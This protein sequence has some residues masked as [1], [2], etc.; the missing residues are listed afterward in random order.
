MLE[1][2]VFSKGDHNNISHSTC[3]SMIWCLHASPRDAQAMPSLESG[4]TCDLLVIKK[5]KMDWKWCCVTSKG[6]SHKAMQ[7][8]PCQ[9]GHWLLEP[10]PPLEGAVHQA[11]GE[12]GGE[13]TDK[14]LHWQLLMMSHLIAS[15]NCQRV[16]KDTARWLHLK[17][18]WVSPSEGWGKRDK[19]FPVP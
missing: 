7:I 19:I 13:I 10:L 16:N 2:T 12:L 8:L 9:L 14:P 6:L 3:F 18:S 1:Q 4:W 15:T 11:V 17:L 5:I